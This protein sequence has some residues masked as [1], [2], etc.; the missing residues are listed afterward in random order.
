MADRVLF[1]TKHQFDVGTIPVK[2]ISKNGPKIL[3]FSGGTA[4]GDI[5]SYLTH[6]TRNA[7]Y[8]TTPFDSGGSSAVLR[9]AFMMPAV[10]DLRSRLMSLANKKLPG[11]EEKIRL[12]GYRLPKQASPQLLLEELKQFFYGTHQL[13][14]PFSDSI[15]A[16]V[17]EEIGFFIDQMP[18]NFDLSGASIGNILLTVRFLKEGRSLKEAVDFFSLWLGVEGIVEPLVEENVHL[19]VKLENG[20]VLRGQHKFTGKNGISI[21][22]PIKEI[23]FTES[24]ESSTPIML[25]ASESICQHIYS[26]DLICFPMGS[27]FSSVVANLLP[28]GITHAIRLTNCIKI[29]IPNLNTDPE[30]FGCSLQKQIEYLGKLLSNGT[31][32]ELYP[33]VILLDKNIDGYIGGIP[34]DWLKEQGIQV[35]FLQLVTEKYSP[36]FDPEKVCCLLLK[37]SKYIGDARLFKCIQKQYS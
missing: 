9:Q 22:S 35:L 6:Y 27:F 10:G 26:A 12:F 8:L 34:H 24:L 36:Y 29:F 37:L 3:F 2:K 1:S 11:Y 33:D 28:I 15:L 21:S 31:G 16:F 17:K 20:N 32:K 23:W 19:C 13:L 4:L 18:E 7:V 30:L 14:Y 25:E 5:A